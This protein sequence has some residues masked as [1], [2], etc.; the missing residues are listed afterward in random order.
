MQTFSLLDI[1]V[2]M[3]YN[4]RVEQ[5]TYIN[6]RVRKDI[7]RKLKIASAL[8]QESMLDMLDRLI[9]QELDRL[10]KKEAGNA[11]VQK[12]QA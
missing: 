3:L 2:R 8:S 5:K 1:D 12:N 11:A 4:A 7:H 9:S 10:Q 6:V